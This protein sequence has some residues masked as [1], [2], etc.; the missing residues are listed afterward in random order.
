MLP[1]KKN[2][3]PNFGQDL[4]KK[5]AER[6]TGTN[7]SIETQQFEQKRFQDV[8]LTRTH[9]HNLPLA[10]L[11]PL[12]RGR[13][14]RSAPAR[15]RRARV[16]PPRSRARSASL[17]RGCSKGCLLRHVRGTRFA[18]RSRAPTNDPTLLHRDPCPRPCPP[19]PLTGAGR[20]LESSGGT[21]G[22]LPAADRNP[23]RAGRGGQQGRPFPFPKCQ[24]LCR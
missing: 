15:A 14:S 19:R 7:A 20:V 6:G 23:L 4:G 9:T 1:L 12:G 18:L 5:S 17:R 8:A 3:H 16:C 11:L 22:R 2:I 24:I 10:R 13:C 21:R